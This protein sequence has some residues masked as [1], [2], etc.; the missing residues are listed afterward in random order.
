[1]TTPSSPLKKFNL[2]PLSTLA[3]TS[4]IVLAQTSTYSLNPTSLSVL[5]T[6]LIQ[7]RTLAAERV[8][9]KDANKRLL[10]NRQTAQNK[11]LDSLHKS[12]EEERK[13][14]KEEDDERERERIRQ[15]GTVEKVLQI[16]SDN[17]VEAIDS[18]R[19]IPSTSLLP[20]PK[21]SLASP[22]KSD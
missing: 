3:S 4:P 8:I 13:K 2:H 5:R 11:L 1:M 19:A 10:S 18:A 15:K 12:K 14:K 7:S 20:T 9:I 21:P 17:Q 6:Q 16:V 22:G